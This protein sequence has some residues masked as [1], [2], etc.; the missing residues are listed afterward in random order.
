MPLPKGAWDVPLKDYV[1]EFK[2]TVIVTDLNT[3]RTILAQTIN[4]SE[5]EDRRWLGRI[6]HWACTN[7]FSIETMSEKDYI[8]KVRE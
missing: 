3:E 4:Y 8:D 5:P 6:T 7:E 2:M 1:K